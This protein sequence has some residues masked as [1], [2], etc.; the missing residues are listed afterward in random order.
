MIIA[1]IPVGTLSNG[2]SI[3]SKEIAK[4]N[5]WFVFDTSFSKGGKKS[6]IKNIFKI[7]IDVFRVKKNSVIYFCF[8][9]HGIAFYKDA[10][11]L[12]LLKIKKCNVTLHIHNNFSFNRSKSI[13]RLLFKGVK[14]IAINEKQYSY[15]C[16]FTDECFLIR[17][18]IP[19]K[20]SFFPKREKNK[21]NFVFFGRISERK[22]FF[23][24]TKLV[25]HFP[26]WNFVVGGL[27]EHDI[28]TRFHQFVNDYSNIQYA[29][30]V[31]GEKKHELLLH[32][33]VMLLL[34]DPWYEA[35][36]LVY[37]E[38]LNYGLVILT[39]RQYALKY[40][41]SSS[42]L[43]LDEML[44]NLDEIKSNFNDLSKVRHKGY[45]NYIYYKENFSFDDYCRKLVDIVEV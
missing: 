28:E 18:A 42:F 32:S 29:G 4:K 3:I 39:T 15:Y 30:F 10:I 16:K 37:L 31:S 23:R 17:N 8:S 6:Y 11:L 1:F 27:I 41:S 40:Y 34:S 35:S 9:P 21:L 7:I 5:D 26:D 43:V 2:A 12:S 33:D 20:V 38:A 22:G 45:E 44:S 24:L 13:K 36:P 19:D 14:I 25:K